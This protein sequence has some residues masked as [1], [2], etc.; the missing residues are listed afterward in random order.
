MGCG[1][2]QV[3]TDS[4]AIAAPDGHDQELDK[5]KEA[6]DE[7]CIETALC[8]RDARFIDHLIHEGK[9]GEESD[10][11]GELGQAEEE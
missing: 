11:L 5:R 3:D 8:S 9:D 10:R 2:A 4:I 6:L 1:S 7:A